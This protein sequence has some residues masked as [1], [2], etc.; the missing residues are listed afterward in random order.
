[1]FEGTWRGPEREPA[2]GSAAPTDSAAAAQTSVAT[3]PPSLPAAHN[4]YRGAYDVATLDAPVDLHA[5][6]LEYWRIIYR[7]KWLIL[8]LV[9]A[10]M[11]IGIIRT[12]ITVPLYSA[13]TRLQI[14]RTETRVVD[15]DQGGAQLA[16]DA[17]DFLKTQFELIQ[18]RALAERVII[19]LRLSED[20]SFFKS[21]EFALFGT[22]Q[23][24]LG[25][26]SASRSSQENLVEKAAKIVL[27][28]RVVRPVPGARLVD[29]TYEDP[30]P[31]RAQA[32][33][34]AYAQA[35]IAA[36]IDKRFEANSY[37]KTFLEDQLQ[38][39]KS[40]LQEADKALVAFSER[41]QMV[42]VTEKSSIAENNLS[43]A[44]AA[45]GLLVSERIKNE[46][47]WKQVS[48]TD[49]IGLPQ[50]LSNSVIAGFRDRRNQLVTE[51]QE[52]LQTFKPSYPSMVE[53]SNKIKEIDRQ[54]AN[55]LATI[56]NSLKAAYENSV[57]QEE[58][59]KQRIESLRA[60][61]LD[62]QKRS[63]QYNLL[64]REVDSTRALYDGLLQRFKEVDVAGGLGANNIFV[65]ERPELPRFPSSPILMRALL[66]SMVL[67]LGLG[68]ASA[69]VLSRLD[70]TYVSSEEIERTT[71]LTILGIIPKSTKEGD[72]EAELSD[73]QSA[74]SEAYR[75]LCTA[76]QFATEKG[77]PQTLSLTSA[78]PSEGKSLTA[79]AIARHFAMMNLKVLL[80]DADMRNPS[81]HKKL[82][83]TNGIGLSN[84]LTGACSPPDAFQTTALPNLTFM[85]AGPLPPNAADLLAGASMASL[86]TLG[87]EVFD[88]IVVDGPPVMQLADAP[89]LTNAVSAT[90]FIIGAGQAR[91]AMV[92]NALRR[93]QTARG[94]VIGA[95]MTKFNSR[96][97]G[98]GYGYGYGGSYGYGYGY[99]AKGTA[100]KADGE[101]AKP[102]VTPVTLAP[103]PA[104]Q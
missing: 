20:P 48:G 83:L 92:R 13:T 24:F 21:R 35:F 102:S 22:L 69:Y 18:S 14:D 44:N 16:A 101:I 5:K 45:L 32:V 58:E 17:N 50:F 72:A 25:R 53:I 99:G 41:E 51:Y 26:D 43:A 66:L 15:K 49:V 76:L 47:L 96:M 46:Q 62:L 67:G 30:S 54:L 34:A 60:E 91:P 63:L 31:A 89:I 6:F 12:L 87:L 4:P 3:I 9:A 68:I 1:M 2:G 11:S 88:F 56:K 8:S 33:A 73:P 84:Y 86:L 10:S 52:K 95:V 78:G 90:V 93:L 103:P 74:I 39:L 28:N 104:G 81:L 59:M 79:V 82:G 97:A 75:S 94:P 65:V 27:K 38:Q 61:V 71:G 23:N 70:D 80:V 36:N 77:L 64:K 40:R 55:E 37:A 19:S 85:C 98:Y 29:I 7:R 100:G 42:V 57:S